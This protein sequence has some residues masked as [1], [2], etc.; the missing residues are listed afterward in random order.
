MEG[1]PDRGLLAELVNGCAGVL[2]SV[3]GIID[4]VGG[5]F[6]SFAE[7]LSGL[8]FPDIFEGEVIDALG[9]THGEFSRILVKAQID[10]DGIVALI[11]SVGIDPQGSGLTDQVEIDIIVIPIS[12]FRPEAIEIACRRGVHLQRCLSI[13]CEGAAFPVDLIPVLFPAPGQGSSLIDFGDGSQSE[14]VHSGN[15]D[16][17]MTVLSHISFCIGI[18][19]CVC[20]EPVVCI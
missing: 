20:I 2:C 19:V 5:I 11:P 16:I 15:I 7:N 1:E 10:V 3:Y 6:K 17:E 14:R 9:H 18:Q 13:A 4:P 8:V 12:I